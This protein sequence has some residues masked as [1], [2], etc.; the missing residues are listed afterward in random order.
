[1]KTKKEEIKMSTLDRV[2][3]YGI[4][5]ITGIFI[6][7]MFL[8]DNEAGNEYVSF[9]PNCSVMYVEECNFFN[10]AA[11]ECRN[12]GG[13]YYSA[14]DVQAG[15]DCQ[16]VWSLD[17]CHRESTASSIAS[18]SSSKSS[19]IVSMGSVNSMVLR[20]E[21]SISSMMSSSSLISSSSSSSSGVSSVVSSIIKVNER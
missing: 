9:Y 8:V 7:S 21:S 6:L 16:H 3:Y 1:M 13:H 4:L 14:G 17:A 19:S 20:Q 11:C 2:S 10:R 5:M 12:S 15:T 18:S